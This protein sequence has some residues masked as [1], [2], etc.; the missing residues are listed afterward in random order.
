MFEKNMG[1]KTLPY[2]TPETAAFLSSL[3]LFILKVTFI[4]K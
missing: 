2:G 4:K 3:A 1:P